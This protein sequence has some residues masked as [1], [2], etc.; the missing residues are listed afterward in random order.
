MNRAIRILLASVGAVALSAALAVGVAAKP[1]GAGPGDGSGNK[2]SAKSCQKGG[3][4][5]LYTSTGQSFSSEEQCTSY[6]AGG[7]TL[8]TTPSLQSQWETACV[9]GGGV[10][11]TTNPSVQW[12]CHNSGGLSQ[13][14]KDALAPICQNAGGTTFTY[15]GTTAPYSSITCDFS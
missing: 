11:E 10:V 7:G 1:S 8:S 4:Q 12:V 6:A 13:A 2:L 5:S 9:N 14:T 15:P 3:W